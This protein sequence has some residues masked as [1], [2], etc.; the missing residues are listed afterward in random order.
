[1]ERLFEMMREIGFDPAAM[2]ERIQNHE[3]ELCADEISNLGDGLPSLLVDKKSSEAAWILIYGGKQKFLKFF[4]GFVQSVVSNKSSKYMTDETAVLCEHLSNMCESPIFRNRQLVF[5]SERQKTFSETMMLQLMD[6]P[7]YKEFTLER[8]G[9]LVTSSLI[10]ELPGL[11]PS[12]FTPIAECMD[13]LLFSPKNVARMLRLSKLDEKLSNIAGLDNKSRTKLV[14]GIFGLFDSSNLPMLFCKF[15]EVYPNLIPYYEETYFVRNY[16]LSENKNALNDMYLEQMFIEISSYRDLSY[17]TGVWQHVSGH[18]VYKRYA[19]ASTDFTVRNQFDEFKNLIDGARANVDLFKALPEVGKEVD[20]NGLSM[21]SRRMLTLNLV[22]ISKMLLD[23]LHDPFIVALANKDSEKATL[24]EELKNLDH[25]N[26]E[27]TLLLSQKVRDLAL[28]FEQ[29]PEQLKERVSDLLFRIERRFTSKLPGRND[30][31]QLTI[32]LN[33]PDDVQMDSPESP[34]RLTV[35]VAPHPEVL[36]EPVAPSE[37]KS[38]PESEVQAQELTVDH[39]HNELLAEIERLSNDKIQLENLLSE[40]DQQIRSYKAK[41]HQ[42]RV[43]D[44]TRS[45]APAVDTDSISKIRVI[46][47]VI[48]GV[49]TPERILNFFADMYPE[50]VIIL[51]S[52]IES[53]ANSADFKNVAKLRQY[54]HILVTDYLEQINSG[55]SSHQAKK[56]IGSSLKSNESDTVNRNQRLKSMREFS[57]N[58]ARHHFSKH[59]AIGNKYGTAN[60]IRLYFEV[61]DKKMIIPYC[62]EHLEVHM[63]S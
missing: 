26:L 14:V 54:V 42:Y 45:I 13:M 18:H 16:V 20:L 4:K 8:A 61:I 44:V 36:C 53:A 33:R 23:L 3:E 51:P 35:D 56:L 5:G 38:E 15:L 60:C 29:A 59:I 40:R 55:A 2:L 22:G 9:E 32:G 37:S 24:I 43:V 50:N 12:K 30:V 46:D 28:G 48:Q 39:M 58:G 34:K 19:Q 10:D 1:M 6:F 63:S 21:M 57:Y 31:A 41:E 49:D 17:K 11:F 47:H 7:E 25:S 27:A 62:G 52:A